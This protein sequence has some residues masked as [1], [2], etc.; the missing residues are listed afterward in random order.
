MRPVATA[1]RGA[2][3]SAVRLLDGPNPLLPCRTILCTLES[4]SF[5]AMQVSP[6]AAALLRRALLDD[7]LARGCTDLSPDV[8][9]LL[10]GERPQD[11][12]AVVAALCVELQRPAGAGAGWRGTGESLERPL[13]AYGCESPKLGRSVA[14]AAAEL[15]RAALLQEGAA[16]L[17]LP[18]AVASFVVLRDA[19]ALDP[20]MQALA[21]AARSRGIPCRR[22]RDACALPRALELGEGCR[23]RRLYNGMTDAT[24]TIGATVAGS[25]QR[26][27]ILLHELGFPVPRRRQART[28]SAA[29]AAAGTLGWPVVVRPDGG[30]DRSR[31]VGGLAGPEA[32]AVAFEFAAR[33]GGGAVLVEERLPGDDHRLLVVGGRLVATALHR[34]DGTACDVLARVHPDNRRL[35]E[36]V[37]AALRLDICGVDLLTPDVAVPFSKLRCAVHGIDARPSLG[38][39]LDGGTAERATLAAILDLLFPAG[40]PH[41][42]PLVLA[43]GDGRADGIAAEVAARLAARGHRVGLADRDGVRVDG[44]RL[45]RTPASGRWDELDILLSHPWCTAAS[46]TAAARTIT[47]HGLGWAACDVAVLAGRGDDP[48]EAAAMAVAAS[49]ARRAVLVDAASEA[50]WQ[51]AATL[52]AHMVNVAGA[53]GLQR[54]LATRHGWLCLDGDAAPWPDSALADAAVALLGEAEAPAC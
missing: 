22:L 31:V 33:S 2:L 6:G 47:D 35:A 23:M 53:D 48:A 11:L 52:P 19:I 26:T 50:A 8:A 29:V 4:A 7:R 38:P 40:T 21:A 18:D 24:G 54:E 28:V 1:A 3:V 45:A 9:P 36:T 34:P 37:A 10:R 20:D 25:R 5:P 51:A 17:V 49:S 16:R 43:C 15:V 44:L 41:G 39:H 27:A 46:A 30:D 32:V 13:L 14:P 12:A 42:I